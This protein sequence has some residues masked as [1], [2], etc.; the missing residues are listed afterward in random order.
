MA[1]EII[2]N[3]TLKL[4]TLISTRN[5]MHK[6]LFILIKINKMSSIKPA[7]VNFY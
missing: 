2:N 5:L 3:I 6:S 4:W 1:Y 7:N